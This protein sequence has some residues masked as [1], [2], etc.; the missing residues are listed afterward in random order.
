MG[1]LAAQ[2]THA[3]G[4]SSP[5]NLPEGTCAVVLGVTGPEA[6]QLLKDSLERKGVPHKAVIEN[7]QPY[8]GQLMALGLVPAP[9]SKLKGLLRGYPLLR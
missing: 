2:V 1:L 3:A 8:S 7:D 9:K 4:E 6:L 5:G